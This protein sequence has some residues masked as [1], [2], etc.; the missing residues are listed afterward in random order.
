MDCE[1]VQG[2]LFAEPVDSQEAGALLGKA[3]NGI[4]DQKDGLDGN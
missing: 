3:F 1:Y 4:E 2:F